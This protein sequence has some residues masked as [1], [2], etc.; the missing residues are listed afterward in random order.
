MYDDPPKK[1]NFVEPYFRP[2]KTVVFK[3]DHPSAYKNP[4]HLLAPDRKMW[5]DIARAR[6]YTAW[7]PPVGG[8][9]R[10][11]KKI[12]AANKGIVLEERQELD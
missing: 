1:D 11:G 4:G 6:K 8:E 7:E 5:E 10:K 3:T 9:E 2:H 12:M